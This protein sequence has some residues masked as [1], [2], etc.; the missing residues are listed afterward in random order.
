M[1][2]DAFNNLVSG[3]PG[4]TRPQ[5]TELIAAAQTVVR[6]ALAVA[7]IEQARAPLLACPRC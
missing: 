1:R 4:L 7:T 2:R 5:L 3:L 6:A